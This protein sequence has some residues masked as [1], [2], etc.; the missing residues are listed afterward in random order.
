LKVSETAHDILQKYHV[1][2]YIQ[3]GGDVV[4]D[5]RWRGCT[6][7]LW[8]MTTNCWYLDTY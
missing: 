5:H 2:S 1:D 8:A 4:F 7:L 3:G 6:P